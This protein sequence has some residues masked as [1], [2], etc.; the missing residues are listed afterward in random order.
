MFNNSQ[1]QSVVR[2]VHTN[3]VP[4]RYLHSGRFSTS[5]LNGALHHRLSLAASQDKSLISLQELLACGASV[6]LICTRHVALSEE[7]SSCWTREMKTHSSHFRATWKTL[8]T[9]SDLRLLTCWT[10]LYSAWFYS[11]FKAFPLGGN[12]WYQVLF[13]YL[14]GRG[15]TWAESGQK[16]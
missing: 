10:Q 1:L 8:R 3:F 4:K 11:G 14:L 15:S 13:Q 6:P 9:P 7:A 12:I 2:V 16:H 5:I